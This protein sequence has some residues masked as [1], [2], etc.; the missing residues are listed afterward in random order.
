MLAPLPQQTSCSELV[1]CCCIRYEWEQLGEG[2]E[3]ADEYGLGARDSLQDTVEAVI[4]TLGMRVREKHRTV[5]A[6]HHALHAVGRLTSEP[7]P[8]HRFLRM[9]KA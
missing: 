6:G 8:S 2:T 4:A 5:V 1:W 7:R 9:V 3:V